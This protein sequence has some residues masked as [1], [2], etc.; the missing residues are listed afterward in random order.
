M[1]ITNVNVLKLK[2]IKN[3]MQTFLTNLV[4]RRDLELEQRVQ[5]E[6]DKEDQKT[7]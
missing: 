4:K 7:C 2:T 5:I 6:G 1:N 3:P